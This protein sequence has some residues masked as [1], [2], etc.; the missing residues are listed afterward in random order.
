[1]KWINYTH[2]HDYITC[3][4]ENGLRIF[5]YMNEKNI[6][7]AD[8]QVGKQ[9]WCWQQRLISTLWKV[10]GLEGRVETSAISF[11]PCSHKG[12]DKAAAAEVISTSLYPSD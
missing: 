10:E 8:K 4:F 5:N 7:A 12:V 6:K 1:M 11:E 2:A 3:D 9:C